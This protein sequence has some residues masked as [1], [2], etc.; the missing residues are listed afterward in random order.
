M[1]I[2]ISASG[3]ATATGEIAV[4]IVVFR[5]SDGATADG[6]YP[7]YMAIDAGGRVGDGARGGIVVNAETMGGG[8]TAPAAGVA[9]SGDRIAV[10]FGNFVTGVAGTL[11]DI[12]TVGDEGEIDARAFATIGVR[13]TISVGTSASDRTVVIRSADGFVDF[14]GFDF[15]GGFGVGAVSVGVVFVISDKGVLFIAFLGD[16]GALVVFAGDDGLVAG[17]FL[18][19]V[20]LNTTDFLGGGDYLLLDG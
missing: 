18:G 9:P 5:E 2:A 3:D 20:L 6:F 11:A 15:A 1:D 10:G 19:E 12:A 16:F 13:I 8:A 4:D 7:H 17:F 14:F